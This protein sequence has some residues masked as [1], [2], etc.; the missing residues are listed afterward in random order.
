MTKAIAANYELAQS[1]VA[2]GLWRVEP[3]LGHVIGIKGLPFRR[4]NSDGYIQIKFRDP[5]DW[6]ANRAVLAHRVVWE[7]VHGPVV[8]GRE[9]NHRNGVK[10]DNR[11]IN[12]EAITHLGN[13][14]HARLTG[15]TTTLYGTATPASKLTEDQVRQIYARARSGER[16]RVIGE[17]FGVCAAVVQHIKQGRSWS[18]VTGVHHSR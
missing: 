2:S 6:R 1:F 9:I 13:V 11:I 17:D 14:R 7:H 12:L 15:L 10:T 16:A 4:R 5:L 18:S 8:E 3:G